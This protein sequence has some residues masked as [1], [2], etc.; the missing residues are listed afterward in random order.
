MSCRRWDAPRS[1]PCRCETLPVQS[2]SPGSRL[3]LREQRD[4]GRLLGR[5]AARALALRHDSKV[6]HAALHRKGLVVRLALGLEHGIARQCQASRLQMLLERRLRILCHRQPFGAFE[7]V[8][9]ELGDCALHRIESAIEEDRAEQCFERVGEDRRAAEATALELAF[10]Q[11]Q[12]VTEPQAECGP[13]ERGLVHERRAQARQVALGK[14]GEA[15]IEE[16]R[17]G[18]VEKSVAEEF[19]PLVVRRAE[20]AMRERLAGECGIG[21]GVSEP[22]LEIGKPL[23]GLPAGRLLAGHLAVVTTKSRQALML[24]TSGTFADQDAVSTVSPASLVISMSSGRIDFTSSIALRR[25]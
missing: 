17:D 3:H 14:V 24:Y 9:E 10:A 6:V 23:G 15:L 13:G 2:Q 1:R 19:E 22:A 20:A 18:A 8:G 7:P 5:A 21:E 4:G 16:Y 25:S 11:P 12:P